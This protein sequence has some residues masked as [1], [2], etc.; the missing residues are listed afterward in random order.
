[1]GQT[2]ASRHPRSDHASKVSWTPR[3]TEK[4]TRLQSTAAGRARIAFYSK[5]SLKNRAHRRETLLQWRKININSADQGHFGVP[6]ITGSNT[7]NPTKNE[8]FR[9]SSS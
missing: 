1:M 4:K 3:L 5:G 8:K 6:K 2:S 7:K 9:I